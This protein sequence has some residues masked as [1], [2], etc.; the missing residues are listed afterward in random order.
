MPNWVSNTLTADGNAGPLAEFTDFINALPGGALAGSAD[1]FLNAII[2]MPEIL[3]GTTAPT[4]SGEFDADGRY[5]EFVE[6]PT[7]GHWTAESY[8]ERKAKHYINVSKAAAAHTETGFGNWYDWSVATW[9]TKWDCEVQLADNSD[10]TW[11]GEFATAWSPPLN[12]LV[13]LSLRFPSVTFTLRWEE[14]QGFGEIVK[15]EA[16]KGT[17]L[18]S[19]DPPI[20]HVECAERNGECWCFVDDEVVFD[21]CWAG[22]AAGNGESKEVVRVVQELY[23]RN[24]NLSY[25]GVLSAAK[26]IVDATGVDAVFD[27]IIEQLNDSGS[28]D[29]QS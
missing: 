7:N 28:S 12:A 24:R 2:P 11:C 18:E 19:W 4:P 27:E 3:H 29:P 1:G 9:G 20:S 25:D 10:G 16:G 26:F 21:D 17:A 22:R 5:M 14:E 6:D 8:A 15:L 13:A 23:D